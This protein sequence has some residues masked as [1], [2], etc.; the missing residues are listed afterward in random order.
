MYGRIIFFLWVSILVARVAAYPVLP[1]DDI[2]SFLRKAY[3]QGY[4]NTYH[5]HMPWDSRE[6]EAALIQLEKASLSPAQQQKWQMYARKYLP[7]YF[8]KY[9]SWRSA[10][11]T[12]QIHILPQISLAYQS[13]EGDPYSKQLTF[14]SVQLG[15]QGKWSD[16]IDYQ[17]YV[18]VGQENR[19][20]NVFAEDYNPMLGLPYNTPAKAHSSDSFFDVNS[21][22]GA[23]GSFSYTWTWGSL[24]FARDWN[25]WG[26]GIW[27]HAALSNTGHNWT[28]D[29]DTLPPYA[30][31]PPS[32]PRSGFSAIGENAPMTQIRYTWN[33]PFVTYIHWMG[34][35]MGLSQYTPS[36]SAGHRL[37]F[38]SNRFQVGFN[39][40]VNYTRN[41]T[42]IDYLIPLLPFKFSEH[43]TGDQDNVTLGT[44]VSI[45]LPYQTRIFAELF[46]DDLV[47]PQELFG[48]FWGNKY[49]LTVGLEWRPNIPIGVALEY[50]RVEPWTHTHHLPLNNPNNQYQSYGSY[51]GSEIPANSHRFQS[52]LVWE[53]FKYI[54]PGLE[55]IYM[56]WGAGEKGAYLLDMHTITDSQSKDFLGK[57]PMT[58][59]QVIFSLSSDCLGTIQANAKFGI[60]W[61]EHAIY[62]NDVSASPI[63]ESSLSFKY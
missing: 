39:E 45:R 29:P 62:T 30:I 38:G 33:L 11:S 58:H 35:R 56:S 8:P 46:L 20:K 12:Q 16:H 14:T 60:E 22:D 41:E 19:F 17:S 50:A 32:A 59:T 5:T 23:T 1:N 3:V 42:E 63:V 7:T 21:F 25:V 51:M 37:E 13:T 48:D 10:D 57:N 55:L 26:P 2:Y 40:V 49:A 4:L 15:L 18:F 52:E 47:S 24:D 31:R 43:F 53:G 6:I 36:Y 28:R 27:Q 9:S 61:L 34:E 44:D 54:T